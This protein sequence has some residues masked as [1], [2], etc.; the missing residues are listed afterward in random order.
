MEI[1]KL[2]DIPSPTTT[3]YEPDVI[4]RATRRD[5]VISN[6]DMRRKF[7]VWSILGEG[8]SITNSWFGI[9]SAF[10]TGIDSGG[11][12]LFVYG[13][14]LVA[15]ISVCIGCSLSELVSAMPNAAGQHFWTM[16]LAP[17][18]YARPLSFVTGYCAWAGSLFAS[19]SVSL[20]VA[21]AAV[22]CWKLNHPNFDIHEWHVFI[23]Y[24]VIN[25][26]AFIFNCSGQILPTL[27]TV[28]LYTSLLSFT[29]ILVYVPSQAPTHQDIKFVFATFINNT[30]W[31]NNAIAFIVGLVNTNWAFSCLDSA[32]HL[33]EE[34]H[35]P[36]VVIPISIM[37]TIAIGF[38]TAWFFIVA[39]FFSLN[40]FDTIVGTL[41]RVPILEL[42]Y[43]SVGNKSAAILLESFIMTTGIGCLIACHTW[44]S[45][46][47]WTFARDGGAPFHES[48]AKINVKLDVPLRAHAVSSTIV[49]LLGC[50]YLI[51][52]TAFNSMIIGCIV[53]P[54]LSYTIP[55]LCLL[56]KGRDEISHGPFWLGDFGHFANIVTIFWT[57]FALIMFSF[58][59]H[60]PVTASNMNYIS[61]IY[62]ILACVVGIDWFSRG[63]LQYRHKMYEGTRGEYES[64]EALLRN[65]SS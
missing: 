33:A 5:E 42:F 7:T 55:L 59:I 21:S 47:C 3:I 56:H 2:D 65:E 36:E 19:A 64:E 30:G 57:M 28:T 14:P 20:A 23:A 35:Q 44:Q 12:A 39:M 1:P 45:R 10:I 49:A 9:S 16:E 50:L 58:P 29:A 46:L 38:T 43:Q 22:G 6:H 27:G 4:P 32:V 62:C 48:L 63:R 15:F 8:F 51:S 25:I 54:Y 60:L 31:S 61:V 41:T 26:F 24:Q 18:K 53:L 11:P 13:I 52:T 34:V 17:K 40:K 37:A